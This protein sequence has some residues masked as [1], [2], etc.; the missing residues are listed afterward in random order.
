[1]SL[2]GCYLQHVVEVKHGGDA[3]S[4]AV[5]KGLTFC[6]LVLHLQIHFVKFFY[7]RSEKKDRQPHSFTVKVQCAAIQ[8]KNN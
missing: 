5:M 7:V 3:D 6:L 1:M 4:E 2:I 8:Q